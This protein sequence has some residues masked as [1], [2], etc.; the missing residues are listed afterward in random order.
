MR[1][2]LHYKTYK[3]ISKINQ[4]INNIYYKPPLL[5]LH[6]LL[7]SMDSWRSQ[8]KRLEQ[9]R[10]VITV[11]LRN[12]GRSPHLKGMSY[13]QM[14][15]DILAIMEY[16]KL[17][18][19]DLLGHSMGGK[20]AMWLALHYPRRIATLIVVDI[21]P[22]TY[23]LWHQKMLIAMLKAPLL[24]FQSR[25]QVD[26]YLSQFIA[27]D[28]ERFFI[29]KNLQKRTGMG[30]KWRCNLKQIVTSYL[31]IAAFPVPAFI[32]SNQSYFI[33]G[34]NSSYILPN[35]H[36][37]IKRLF[38]QSEIHTIKNSSHL[39]HIEQADCFYQLLKTFLK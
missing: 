23:P 22:K 18:T 8:A 11:D 10:T 5:I 7:G 1:S 28:S 29:S 9:S 24:T 34:E 13:Q 26:H 6:G 2:L 32:F 25:Q 17:E 20:V 12:H 31:K 3:K 15:L 27:N 36:A 39:P 37:L 4:H 38:T 33:R 30:Y 16:E 19:I 35:D 21:A 14:G